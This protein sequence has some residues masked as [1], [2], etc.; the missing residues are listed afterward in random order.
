MWGRGD[1]VMGMG[2]GGLAWR[3]CDK[4]CGRE[5]RDSRGIGGIGE[6]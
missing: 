2:D 3:G 6:G 4:E 1:E 5:W